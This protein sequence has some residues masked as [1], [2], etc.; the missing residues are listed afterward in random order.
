MS[1]AHLK[2]IFPRYDWVGLM[3]LL[4]DLVACDPPEKLFFT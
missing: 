2:L 1:D 3:R 4:I